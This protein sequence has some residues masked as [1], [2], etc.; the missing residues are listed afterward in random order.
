MSEMRHEVCLNLQNVKKD[1]TI[2][3]ITDK[4][5]C[6]GCELLLCRGVVRGLQPAQILEL[7]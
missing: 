2:D 1:S 7:F 3:D 4:S 5:F 6:F